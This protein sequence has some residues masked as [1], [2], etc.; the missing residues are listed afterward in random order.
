MEKGCAGVAIGIYFA[1]Q[2]AG[3]TILPFANTAPV[4]QRYSH[5]LAEPVPSRKYA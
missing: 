4:E 5:V 3:V 2:V 1:V